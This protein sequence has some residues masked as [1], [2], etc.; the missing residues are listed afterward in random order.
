MAQMTPVWERWLLTV[1]TFYS[2]QLEG[3]AGQ[4]VLVGFPHDEGVRRNGGRV[5]AKQA[6]TVVRQYVG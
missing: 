3:A 6:P 1:I 5:G 2:L 4:V